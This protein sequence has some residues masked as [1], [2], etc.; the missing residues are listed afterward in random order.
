MYSKR[1]KAG[2]AFPEITAT[3]Q[4]GTPTTLG[5]PAGD[6]DWK[7]VLVYRGRH[8]PLCTKYL[9]RLE[10]YRDRLAGI[11]VDLVA[12]S[13]D[14]RDQLAAHRENLTVSF[15]LAYGLTMDRMQALGL[16]ISHPRSA[17]ETDH[18]FPEPALFVINEVGDIQV[19]DISNNPFVRPELET[20]VNGLAFV[21]EKDYPIRG[22]YDYV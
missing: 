7:M 20:L 3:L 8:C 9:N 10:G 17:Q 11:G 6:A 22:T 1:L 21:R 13:A 19:A 14:S 15:P 18:D 16:Y 4:D 5:R 12:V 2:V